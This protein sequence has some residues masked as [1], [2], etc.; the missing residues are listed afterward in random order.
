ME[1]RSYL[2]QREGRW[3]RLKEPSLKRIAWEKRPKW[4]K[5]INL[6]PVVAGQG[7]AQCAVP[8]GSA[9]GPSGGSGVS[10]GVAAAM[11]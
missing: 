10:G 9:V 3:E 2:G 1:V 5:I 11:N 7:R 4:R 8:V 6:T